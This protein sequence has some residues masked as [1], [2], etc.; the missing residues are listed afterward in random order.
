MIDQEVDTI[1]ELNK[2]I[3]SNQNR[4]ITIYDFAKDYRLVE[5][6]VSVIIG[7]SITYIVRDISTNIIGPIISTA[8]FHNHEIITLFGIEFNIEKIIEGIIFAILSLS[9]L[10]F[11]IKYILRDIVENTIVENRNKDL[12]TRLYQQKNILLQQQNINLL[13]DIKGVLGR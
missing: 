3:M 11:I 8:V 13:T 4:E 7:I 9:I 6:T 12:S 10:Y 5:Y 1:N 2:M